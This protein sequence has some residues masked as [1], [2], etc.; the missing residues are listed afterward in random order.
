MNPLVK[1]ILPHEWCFGL[2]LC[3]MWL[4]LVVHVG[5]IHPQSLLYLGVL[6]GQVLFIRRSV[7]K[8]NANTWKARLWFFPVMMSVVFCSMKHS[9]MLVSP[10]K[11]DA[12]LANVDTVMFGSVLA[13]K[14]EAL[15]S[16]GLTEILSICYLLFFPYLVQS[17]FY[18][19]HRNFAEFRA[20]I[21]GMFTL[22]G[23]GFLGYS[24]MPAGGP[25]LAM[26]EIFSQELIGWAVTRFNHSV[27][28]LG[29]SGVDVFPSLHCG[30]SFFILMFDYKH[31]RNRFWLMLL[32]CIGIWIAT[33]YLRYHY[34]ADVVA[35]FLLAAFALWISKRV[36]A[37]PNPSLPSDSYA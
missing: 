15:Y 37:Q 13:K 16:P 30:I 24:V 34:F 35:G 2:F 5:I 32:P 27:V 19:S 29:S 11:V 8:Q 3:S 1:K 6:L 23:I 31:S 28:A 7:K 22:Y 12:S 4:R 18:Y 17:W 14:A 25:H 10:R 21:A 9:V 26:P 20:L 36:H 33:I